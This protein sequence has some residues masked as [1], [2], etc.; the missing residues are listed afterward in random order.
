MG[1]PERI[2]I[3]GGGIG[4]LTLAIA[5]QK[6]GFNVVVYE[7]APS[8]KPLGAGLVIS[9]NAINAF[10][11]IGIRDQILSAGSELK[12]ISIKDQRGKTLTQIASARITEKYRIANSV[13][14]HRADLHNVLL[15][16]VKDDTI[17]LGKGCVDFIQSE[18][19]VKLNFQDGSSTEADYVI[20][21]D[22]VHSVFRKKLVPGS[23]P[24]YAGYTCWRAVVDN[25]PLVDLSETSEL[26]GP[27]HRFGLV[28]VSKGRLYWF[29]CINA[30]QNNTEMRAYG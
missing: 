27:G 22:G 1:R 9:A 11:E 2:A 20:A 3:V 7:Q 23:N 19:A 13:A 25:P 28:P 10:A 5:M 14:I 24:R 12:K 18:K 17:Q 8:L 4:G 21:C 26:W 29:A 6:K 16:H 15:Q 30:K